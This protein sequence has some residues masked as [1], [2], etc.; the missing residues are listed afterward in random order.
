MDDHD[1]ADTHEG[2][3]HHDKDHNHDHDFSDRVELLE[4]PVQYRYLSEEEL[5]TFLRPGPNWTVAD[6]GSG[7]GFYTDAV[8]PTV[9]KLYAVDAF[10]AMHE[11]YRAKGVP[12]NVDLLTSDVADLPLDDDVLDA[13]LSIRT[14]HHGVSDALGEVARV[15]RPGGRFVVFD[16]SASGEGDR[17]R[18][19]DP[20]MCFDLATVQSHLLDAGFRVEWAQERRETFVVVATLRDE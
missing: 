14:F 18:G 2:A 8:A 11:E 19:P 17:D 5:R 12:S 7:T 9:E 4:D 20:E 16:W 13:A 10:E 3:H 1:A 15:L 6:L